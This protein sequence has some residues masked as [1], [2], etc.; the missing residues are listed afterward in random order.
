LR[1]LPPLPILKSLS[2]YVNDIAVVV[3]TIAVVVWGCVFALVFH[4]RWRTWRHWHKGLPFTSDEW[5]LLGLMLVG[6]FLGLIYMLT[7]LNGRPP[8]VPPL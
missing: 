3:Y 1:S 2:T 8:G 7:F 5:I 4:R 6:L